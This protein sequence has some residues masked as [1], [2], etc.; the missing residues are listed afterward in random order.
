MPAF[1]ARAAISIS[2][3]YSSPSWNFLPTT[4]MAAV[5]ASRTVLGSTPGVEGRL[6]LGDGGGAV[7]R[8]DGGGQ[9]GEVGHGVVLL[10]SRVRG[11]PAVGSALSPGGSRM[12]C[13]A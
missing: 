1:M 9:G 13:G 11:C 10:S 12:R 3:T 8:L 2:G 4:S 6:G 5:I 7:A